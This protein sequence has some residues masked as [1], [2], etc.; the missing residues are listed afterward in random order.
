MSDSQCIFS[1][2]P[3]MQANFFS[4]CLVK[5]SVICLPSQIFLNS[6]FP[7][8]SHIK[9]PMDTRALLSASLILSL[10]SFGLLVYSCTHAQ[11]HSLGF[12]LSLFPSFCKSN[13][14]VGFFLHIGPQIHSTSLFPISNLVKSSLP[15]AFSC[16][17]FNFNPISIYPTNFLHYY[18]TN[19]TPSISKLEMALSAML[20]ELKCTSL[21]FRVFIF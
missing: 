2:H 5:Q 11:S 9:S 1:N 6:S 8:V 10:C 19:T 21:S 17:V 20:L 4:L 3:R 16:Y 18:F 14:I 7:V 15:H 13:H 12:S